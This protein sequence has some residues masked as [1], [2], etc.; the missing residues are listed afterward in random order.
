MYST[1]HNYDAIKET[2]PV[3]TTLPDHAEAIQFNLEPQAI[4]DRMTVKRNGRAV[5]KVLIKWKHHLPKDTTWEFYYVLKK[6]YAS[7]NP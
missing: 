7:F 3:S 6:K 2:K 5:T 1:F 4:L